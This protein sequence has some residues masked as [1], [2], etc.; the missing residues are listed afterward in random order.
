MIY[1]EVP[2]LVPIT[3]RARLSTVH[4][5]LHTHILTLS[6][7]PCHLYLFLLLWWKQRNSRQRSLVLIL[8][9]SLFQLYLLLRWIK[10]T[11]ELKIYSHAHSLILSLATKEI[12]TWRLVTHMLIL[13]CYTL[14]SS[15]ELQAR[16]RPNSKSENKL[17]WL[18]WR[19]SKCGVAIYISSRRVLPTLDCP[20]CKSTPRTG[21]WCCS[22]Q[23]I[24]SNEEELAL[25]RQS[26]SDMERALQ[27]SEAFVYSLAAAL[28]EAGDQRGIDLLKQI[29]QME[30]S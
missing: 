2:I 14:G 30:G 10:G 11:Q 24:E 9:F 20:P 27:E 12:K 25:A 23:V 26:I 4:I 7:T 13:S 6:H 18:V 5:S 1:C 21:I 28:A 29:Q 19:R 22:A 3:V 15:C 16:V 8:W 17:V